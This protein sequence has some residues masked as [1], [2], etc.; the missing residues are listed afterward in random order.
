MILRVM[1]CDFLKNVYMDWQFD[2]QWRKLFREFKRKERKIDFLFFSKM[3]FNVFEIL[4]LY[5]LKE[6]KIV[7]DF[8]KKLVII[9]N[10][11][12]ER[13]VMF[14]EIFMNKLI[15]LFVY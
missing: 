11:V 14:Y 13:V 8:R 1:I 9:Q 2:C 7:R 12:V 4:Y 5:E 6:K 3:S 10:M 15:Y